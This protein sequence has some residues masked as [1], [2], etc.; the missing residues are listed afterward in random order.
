MERGKEKRKTWHEGRNGENGH[1][2]LKPTLGRREKREERR[3]DRI[4]ARK[5]SRRGELCRRGG[6]LDIMSSGTPADVL[7]VMEVCMSSG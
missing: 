7:R 3:S 2:D 1:G 6:S 4:N 5:G